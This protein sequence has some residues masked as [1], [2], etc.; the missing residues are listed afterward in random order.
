MVDDVRALTPVTVPD[1]R[2][3]L[4]D[5]TGSP[6]D[7]APV[8]VWHHESPHTGALYE[9]LLSA[10]ATAGVRLVAFT[11]PGYGGASRLGPAR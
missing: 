11:R 10:A 9:P 8:V 3:V 7:D 4:V 1:G 6:G 2:T 5:D